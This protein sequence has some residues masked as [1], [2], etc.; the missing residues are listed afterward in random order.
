MNLKTFLIP[1]VSAGSSK[2]TSSSRN[3]IRVFFL[4]TDHRPPLNAE[5][6]DAKTDTY[7]NDIPPKR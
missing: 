2:L 5:A 1:H 6:P 4:K 7:S 3:S